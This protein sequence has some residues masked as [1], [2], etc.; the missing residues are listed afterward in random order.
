MARDFIRINQ[1]VNTA[2]KASL[3]S[4]YILSLRQTMELGDRVKGILEHN[5]DGTDY[6]DVESLFGVPAGSG[7]AVYNLVLGAAAG[8]R[9][10]DGR[11]LT[12]RVG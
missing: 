2:T 12:E 4:Q 11:N 8:V 6:T 3:L 9:S 10:A 1:T 7:Q 5:T